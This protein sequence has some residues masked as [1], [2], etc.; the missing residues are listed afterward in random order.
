MCGI[1]NV[2]IR[3]SQFPCPMLDRKERVGPLL[4]LESTCYTNSVFELWVCN[5]TM[6]Q[7]AMAYTWN[8]FLPQLEVWGIQEHGTGKL[9]DFRS[10]LWVW[11]Q[12]AAHCLLTCTLCVLWE[13]GTGG[14]SHSSCQHTSQEETLASFSTWY[15]FSYLTRHW[16]LSILNTHL[17]LYTYVYEYSRVPKAPEATK[18]KIR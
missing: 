1:F 11:R 9:V 17:Y 12:Q 10:L 6:P 15:L 5:D 7:T 13:L 2:T 8:F 3:S 18:M 16:K 14:W 4:P